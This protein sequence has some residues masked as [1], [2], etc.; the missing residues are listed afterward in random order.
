V[1][2]PVPR[3]SA[4]DNAAR[5]SRKLDCNSHQQ[6]TTLEPKTRHPPGELQKFLL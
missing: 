1:V 3:Q 4:N 6:H 2:C 5:E